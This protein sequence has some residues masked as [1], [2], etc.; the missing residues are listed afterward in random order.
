MARRQRSAAQTE[1]EVQRSHPHYVLVRESFEGVTYPAMWRCMLHDITFVY[2]ASIL[3]RPEKVGCPGCR[4]DRGRARRRKQL[5]ESELNQHLE[6]IKARFGD[7]YAR[8]YAFRSA[9]WKETEI[10]EAVG[11]SEPLVYYRLRKIRRFLDPQAQDSD[12]DSGA[13]AGSHA[14]HRQERVAMNEDELTL[15]REIG[16]RLRYARCSLGLSLSQLSERT[17]GVLSKSRISN[18]EQ[19]TRRMSLEAARA[20]TGAL[21]NVT[22]AYLLCLDDPMNLSADEIDLIETYRQ[23][24]AKEQAQLRKRAI[25]AKNVG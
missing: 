5:A 9:G 6:R 25:K 22:P 8:I 12:T 13:A 21:G 18:Y 19:G 23:I 14:Q 17:D 16:Q 4:E 1:R 3:C 24:D 15:T 10:G 11:I 20:L 7:V 2:E